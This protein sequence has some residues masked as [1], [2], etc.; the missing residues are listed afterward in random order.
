MAWF[1]LDIGPIEARCRER[2]DISHIR[3]RIR[4]FDPFDLRMRLPGAVQIVADQ[5][6]AGKKVYIHCTAGH[7]RLLYQVGSCNAP[8]MH[9]CAQLP[10]SQ[11]ND[12]S[13]V[14]QPLDSSQSQKEGAVQCKSFPAIIPSNLTS[15]ACF[16]RIP[17]VD[18]GVV[19]GIANEELLH[20]MAQPSS[21][22][23]ATPHP[24]AEL[25]TTCHLHLLPEGQLHRAACCTFASM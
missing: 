17:P 22:T 18:S 7:T 8:C 2:G 1:D 5:V 13:P 24:T 11:R 4:D 12:C 21:C 10:A 20:D 14:Q 23:Q 9:C 15:S 3:Y 25:S 16:L 19:H 6:A